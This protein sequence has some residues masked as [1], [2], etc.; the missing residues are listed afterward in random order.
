M[1]EAIAAEQITMSLMV[2][3]MINLLLQSPSVA[4]ADLSSLR[5]VLYGA[6]PM[7]SAVQQK[8][9]NTLGPIFAQGYGN[10]DT[11]TAHALVDGWY[12][13]GDV[14]YA[15]EAGYLFIVDRAKDMIIS[16]GENIYTTE[17]ENAVYAHPAVLEAAAFGV[18]HV[19]W[20]EAVHVEVVTKPGTSA[21]EDGLIEHCRALIA[22]YK[23]PRSINLRT[24]E[25]P[26][27][28][29]GAGKILKRDLRAPYWEGHNR[30]IN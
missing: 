5:A 24:H 15:D 25:D 9:M 30:S 19:H 17:I 13:S 18:P 20:G 16:R 11:E 3:T 4:G 26:L 6:S 2:P 10:R 21:D 23:V 1:V 22:G 8:A 7:P 29:S 28:K 12:R 14:A 27:P